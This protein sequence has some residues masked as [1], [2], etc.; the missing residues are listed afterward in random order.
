MHSACRTLRRVLVY[1][2][3]MIR[4]YNKD[5]SALIGEISEDQL[6]TL[7]DLFEEEDTKDQDYFI[8]ADS[9]QFMKEKQADE[10]LIAMLEP[11]ADNEEGLEIE[12]KRE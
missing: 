5:S 9:L 6:Q 1:A 12:W 3:P 2:R 8:N 4:L 7:I 10:A 11:L